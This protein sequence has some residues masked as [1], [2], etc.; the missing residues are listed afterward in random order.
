[1]LFLY[2]L[3][4]NK[5]FS[6]EQG[7]QIEVSQRKMTVGQKAAHEQNLSAATFYASPK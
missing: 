6:M 5:S 1:M 2:A 7:F 4:G 3:L